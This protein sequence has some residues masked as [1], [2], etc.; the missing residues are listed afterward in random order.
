MKNKSVVMKILIVGSF[1]LVILLLI[2]ILS[3][4]R[5]FT[6]KEINTVEK[7][8]IEETYSLTDIE[9]ISFD[10]K[11]SNSLFEVSDKEELVV[12]QNSKEEKFYLNYKKKGKKL[13]FEE[14]GY[15]INPQKK[16]YIVYIP[17]SYIN[18]V[19]I[20]NG[21]G[22]LEI[23]DITNDL[24]INNNAGEV[25]I[26][27]IGNLKIKDVSGKV[28]IDNIEGN[29]E[30]ESSTGNF[31]IGSLVGTANMEAITGDIII[32]N[33]DIV[34][35]SKFE[36]V[37]G[38]IIIDMKEKAVCTVNYS[39]ERGK[40]NISDDVCADGLNMNIIDANNMTGI[41]KIY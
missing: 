35:D 40:T 16:K 26:N 27:K 28:T 14:D 41:I 25:N 24:Y 1:I 39:N 29:I 32:N 9:D 31:E 15:I 30:A 3:L 33:F 17:K 19:T 6:P 34:G 13:Y 38:D 23:S 18:K 36:N 2:V 12:V 7:K 20:I 10:F 37:S 22:E 21:F 4:I 11:K 8:V 5:M